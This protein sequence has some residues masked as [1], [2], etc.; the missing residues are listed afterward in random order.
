MNIFLYFGIY[1]A[2]IAFIIQFNKKSN[3]YLI[4]LQTIILLVTLTLPSTTSV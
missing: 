2:K 1:V 3:D 4:I